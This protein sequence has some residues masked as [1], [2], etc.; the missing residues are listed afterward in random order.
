MPG[1]NLSNLAI[2]AGALSVGIGFGLQS[3]VNNFVSGLILLG[4]AADQGRRPGRRRRRGRLCAQDQRPL[5]RGRDLRARSRARSE[6]LFH[7][8]ESEELDASRQHPPHRDPGW[9]GL[10]LRSAQ[11]QGHPAE[12]RAG[13]SQCHELRL[14]LPSISRISGRTVSISSST[15]SS[16]TSTRPAA[17]ARIC[18]SPSSKLSTRP[19]SQ[20]RFGRPTSPCGTWIGCARRSPTMSPP[21]PAMAR[22]PATARL[23]RGNF[24]VRVRA[25]RP[26]PIGTGIAETF[27][28]DYG[29]AARRRGDRVKGAISSG[30][31][32]FS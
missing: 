19:A 16:T 6:F 14:L 26:A 18:G 13:Q 1:F 7:H 12:G 15:R 25:Y 21:L 32:G 3:V 31:A 9:R 23:P 4:G 20:F 11:G 27:R 28:D 24:Q 2:V 22:A 29:L 10:R 17:R 8:R 30:E 5:D